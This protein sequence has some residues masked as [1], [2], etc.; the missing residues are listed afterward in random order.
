MRNGKASLE[1]ILTRS[2][3]SIDAPQ[4]CDFSI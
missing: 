1:M 4:R 2:V 3:V